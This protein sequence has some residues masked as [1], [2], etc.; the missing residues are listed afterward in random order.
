[1]LKITF[2]YADEMSG[3]KWQRQT[4]VVSSLDECKRI[5]GLGIDCDYRIISIEKI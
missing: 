5:Y 3:W 1:M 4:C 2:E